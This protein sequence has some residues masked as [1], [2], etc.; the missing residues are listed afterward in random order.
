M[1]PEDITRIKANS[2]AIREF[3]T[4]VQPHGVG[5]QL[6]DDEQKASGA[7]A[8]GAEVTISL[9]PPVVPRPWIAGMR[10]MAPIGG[11]L[12]LALA[13]VVVLA[14][15][16][17]RRAWPGFGVAPSSDKG[18]LAQAAERAQGNLFPDHTLTP[19]RVLS[20]DVATVCRSGYAR[21]VRPKGNEW[22]RLKDEAYERYG[23]PRGH[24]SRVGANGRREAAYEVDHLVP[25]ELGGDPTSI[26][27]LWPEPIDSA[28]QKDQV[29]DALHR[30]V[31]SGQMTLSDAQRRIEENWMTATSGE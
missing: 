12:F 1:K 8:E 3:A 25:L 4:R 31:C 18:A 11:A 7:G 22:R 20:V 10:S 6:I 15:T 27:N 29:E 23:L 14:Y 13:A 2:D 5:G 26:L 17:E 30:K 21:S 28:K 16:A 19:G 9:A 24:R